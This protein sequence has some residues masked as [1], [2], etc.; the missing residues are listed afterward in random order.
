MEKMNA[1]GGAGEGAVKISK[2]LKFR[3]RCR[4]S[5]LK[6]CNFKRV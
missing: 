2:T 3:Q 6:K 1:R 4:G 5:V